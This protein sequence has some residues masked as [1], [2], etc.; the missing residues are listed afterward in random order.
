MSLPRI[1]AT[2][3]TAEIQ[4]LAGRNQMLD[5]EIPSQYDEL[6]SNVDKIDALTELLECYTLSAPPMPSRP[7]VSY[8]RPIDGVEAFWRELEAVMR[9]PPMPRV[10]NAI[11]KIQK[12]HMV[13]VHSKQEATK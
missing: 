5:W 2:L 9:T 12:K 4:N 3:I 1:D 6:L 13:L 8:K 7:P 10:H 11:N